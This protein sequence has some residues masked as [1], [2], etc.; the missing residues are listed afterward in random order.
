MRIPTDPRIRDYFFRE[1]ID[2]CFDSRIERCG[3]YD[4]LKSYYLLGCDNEQMPVASKIYSALDTLR[5]F[6]FSAETTRFTVEIGAGAPRGEV[7]KTIPLRNRLMDEWH[8]SGTDI[9]FGDA[10]L[11]SLV[12]NSMFLYP[13]W[14]SG[15]VQTSVIEPHQV[16]VMREDVSGLDVQEAFC[17]R[18]MTTRSQL[19]SDLD[20]HPK[21]EEIMKR[22]AS[23]AGQT[24]SNQ[25]PPTVERII[26]SQVNPNVI[27]QASWLSAPPIQYE[28]K[29]RTDMVEMID[30]WIW[31]DA[32]DDWHR[33]TRS[34]NEVT[35]FD[36]PN[37][38]LPAK[39]NHKNVIE[40][41]GE[42]PLIQ[43]CPNPQ[44][45]YFWGRSEIANLLM[46]QDA[47]AHRIQQIQRLGD[48]VVDPPKR[49]FGIDS[50]SMEVM[51]A[52]FTPHGYVPFADQSGKIEDEKISVPGEL[53]EE[54]K[55][56]DQLFSEQMGV[57][58]VMQGRG[59][60]GVRSRGQTDT[61]ARLG[62]SRAKNR[63]MIIEDSL[64][65]LGTK[66]L[67]LIQRHDDKE[68]IY[69]DAAGKELPFVP[70][71]FTGN[72]T[73]KVDGHTMSPI[74]V[75]DEK[76]MVFSMLENKMIT[77]ERALEMV[78]PVMLP[79]LLEDLKGIE[80]QEAQA[81]QAEQEKEQ[82]E[83]RL[84]SVK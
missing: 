27:G 22:M 14:K 1:L 9:T 78:H 18:Y 30:L 71:M 54:I 11:W 20:G 19:L 25:L 12:Y 63:A 37:T 66:M 35:I 56:Y 45:N 33:V 29:M 65:R 13:I 6:L 77:R 59:E 44:Y 80:K 53:W 17:V 41:R 48:K 38:Y 81:A 3:Q 32:T 61:L 70:A 75:E 69:K 2:Q 16:G 46:I 73:V 4:R 47:W 28:P 10:L 21:L 31:D 82:Q 8:D 36:R 39:R 60:P 58:N 42:A 24:S 74:F 67:R 26:T 64:D 55:F 79:T 5:S 84:R 50:D 57:N 15:R 7:H 72:S 40:R 62:S 83:Q 43:I 23:E 52:L 51:D 76:N 34:E 49:G 68:L